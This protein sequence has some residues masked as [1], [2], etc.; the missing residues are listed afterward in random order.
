MQLDLCG[1]SLAKE[2]MFAGN[3]PENPF[4]LTLRKSFLARWGSIFFDHTLN[5]RQ[6]VY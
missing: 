6:Y 4:E 2:I 5:R 1:N 3:A